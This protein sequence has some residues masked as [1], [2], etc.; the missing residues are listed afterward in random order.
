MHDRECTSK[1]C[2]RSV[3]F[4]RLAPIAQRVCKQVTG[5]FAGYISKKQPTGRYELCASAGNLAHMLDKTNGKPHL[6]QFAKV[7]NRMFIDLD[8][9]GTLRAAP[10]TFSTSPA[11]FPSTT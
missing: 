3:S 7:W 1:M 8:S 5:Y 6:A 9:E 4:K 11:S 2:L 10:V